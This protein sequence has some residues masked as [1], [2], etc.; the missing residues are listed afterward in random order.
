VKPQLDKLIW[1][2]DGLGFSNEQTL[3]NVGQ[4][5]HVE[6]I[7]E[8]QGSLTESLFNLAVNG[9]SRLDDWCNQ[10]LNSSLKLAKMFVEEGC[11]NSVEGGLFGEGN[12]D[13]PEPSLETG[14]NKEGTS[15]GVHGRNVHRVLDISEGPFGAAFIPV[16]VVLVLAE[17]GNGSLSF[18]RVKLRHV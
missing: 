2:L 6:L 7:V 16:L 9:Q 15:S 10:L 14:V 1:L 4:V 3:E 12:C 17:E 8:V 11:E 18:I 5:A 13:N